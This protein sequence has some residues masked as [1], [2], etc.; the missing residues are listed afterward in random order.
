MNRFSLIL[1]LFILF[2]SMALGDVLI[3][4][5]TSTLTATHAFQVGFWQESASSNALG[6]VTLSTPRGGTFMSYVTSTDIGGSF[7]GFIQKPF[8]SSSE[9]DSRHNTLD[10]LFDVVG[11]PVQIHFTMSGM[12][13]PPGN[14]IVRVTDAGDTTGYFD[15]ASI[16][17]NP[18]GYLA[19]QEWPNVS[20]SFELAPGSYHLFAGAGG[21]R[22]YGPGGGQ[23]VSGSGS[24]GF[25]LVFVPNTSSTAALLVGGSMALRR[26]RR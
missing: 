25:D 6:A 22:A 18:G 10:V 11:D 13:W 26:R 16:S 8:A 20:H 2:P 9:S 7:S 14:S 23:P 17:T 4:S 21:Y 15:A 19:P 24:F 1:S 3:V 5:R 12:S